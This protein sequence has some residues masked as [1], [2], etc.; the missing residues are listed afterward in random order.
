[1]RKILTT[2]TLFCVTLAAWAAYVQTETKQDTLRPYSIKVVDRR[3]KPVEGVVVSISRL[4]EAFLTD[5]KGLVNLEGVY[6]SDTVIVFLP[7]I[8]ES[9]IPCE[10]TDSVQITIRSKKRI[11]IQDR[12]ELV[13]LHANP[14]NTIDNVP[15]LLK[16]VCPKSG[17][18][19]SGTNTGF[20]YFTRSK[21]HDG[22]YQGYQFH[23]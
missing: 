21:R 7:N 18:T 20:V 9:H 22:K 16:K 17:R 2:I 8:G 23:Q 4:K 14:S 10:G 15:E 5:K 3:N 6:D 12:K 1:M 19:A 11:R 13:S